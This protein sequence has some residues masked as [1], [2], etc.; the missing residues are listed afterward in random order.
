MSDGPTPPAGTS[1]PRNGPRPIATFHARHGRT[2]DATRALLAE[3]LPDIDV[4]HRPD[5]ARPL[6]VEVGAGS[7]I[8]ARAF[9]RARPDVDLIA[10]E[11]HTPGVA[12]MVRDQVA[13][14]LD[15]LFVHHGDAVGWLDR[16]PG[17]SVTAVHV[18]FPD[19]WPKARHHKR[20]FIRPDILDRVARVLRDGAPLV[21][22]TD[23]D[24]YVRW[25]DAT[26]ADHPDFADGIAARA[27]WRPVT[28]YEARGVRLGHTIHDRTWPR[29]H[30]DH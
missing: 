24:D 16:Q 2:S 19:P 14:R 1:S 13:D 18:L 25:A 4:A 30:R 9:A 8:A 15:N 3:R 27:A 10:I 12:R 11:V 29:R 5:P 23:V 6:V 7:G 26:V 21:L 28:D 22:A 20:R 17:A